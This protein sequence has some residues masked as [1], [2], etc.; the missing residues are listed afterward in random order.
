MFVFFHLSTLFMRAEKRD[1]TFSPDRPFYPNDDLVL[2]RNDDTFFSPLLLDLKMQIRRIKWPP[3]RNRGNIT[4]GGEEEREDKVK[5]DGI[6]WKKQTS[7]GRVEEVLAADVNEA[8]G[9]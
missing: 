4:T 5:S 9:H 3:E 2:Y 7:S 1:E 8:S 6:W